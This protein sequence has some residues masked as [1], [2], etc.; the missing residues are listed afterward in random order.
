MRQ[1]DRPSVSS[2]WTRQSARI[3]HLSS[4]LYGLPICHSLSSSSASATTSV[5]V[6]FLTGQLINYNTIES[7]KSV[8][9]NALLKVA[10]EPIWN[11]IHRSSSSSAASGSSIPRK[12]TAADLNPLLVITFADLKKYKYYYWCA[13]PALLQKPAWEVVSD[14]WTNADAKLVSQSNGLS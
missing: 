8:D 2:L 9:K 11:H 4:Y 14:E 12:V 13:F 1:L 3:Q 5:S 6:P 10:A 7:F